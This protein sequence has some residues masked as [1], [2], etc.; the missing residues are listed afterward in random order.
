M[1]CKAALVP[2]MGP[3]QSI[4]V[5]EVEVAEPAEDEVRLKVMTCT[6]CHSD[7]HALTGD[8]GAYD[9]PGMAGHEIAGV[10]TKVGA[11]VTYV[12]PGDRVICSEV[13]AGCGQCEPCLG[14]HQ[15]F[16]QDH[17]MT[18]ELFRIPGCHT[19]LNGER[20]IQTCSG[21]S[22]FAEYCNA[23]E[24]M[25]CKLD[26]DIPF[27]VGSAL[28][29]G[30]M[31]GFGAV[32]NRCQ[33]KP[34]EAFAVCGCGGVG[35]SAI[36]GA[37]YSG[38][39]PIIAIDT[40]ESKLEAAR[41]FGATHVLNPKECDVV[42]EVKKITRGLGV[43]HSFV[44]VAG[45]GI[46]KQMWDITAGWGQMVIVGHG[47]HDNEW[48]NDI[49]YF[50]FLRGRKITGCVMG[51]VTL[52]RDIP[53]YMEMYRNGQIDID[54]LL[55]NRFTLDQIEEALE[56]SCSGALKDVVYIGCPVPEDLAHR[57]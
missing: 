2:K 39:C 33:V 37:K 3:Y 19:R 30:F 45:K 31:S 16:C 42:E 46:K 40:M 18:T 7:I 38:A 25:L 9:G 27:E 44:A 22:G 41:K 54:G 5:E 8:H 14:G 26:D 12:K 29:C 43:E 4:V 56:D 50:D 1:R 23:H 48:C 35:L 57:P 28:A 47:H 15:W 13:R 55:T 17:A 10:V 36:M 11:K 6:I 32:L 24:S 34:G 21:T 20:C 49:N 53:K 51:G 52:R